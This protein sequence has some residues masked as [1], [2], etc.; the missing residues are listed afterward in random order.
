MKTVKARW[1]AAIWIMVG[2]SCGFILAQK[3]APAHPPADAPDANSFSD[4]E[5][6][7]RMKDL[8]PLAQSYLG[9]GRSSQKITGVRLTSA[10]FALSLAG[11][12][13]S[14]IRY[15]DVQGVGVKAGYVVHW[16]E[17][18]LWFPK[19][20]VEESGRFS[21][22]LSRL[23]DAAHGGRSCD[24]TRYLVDTKAELDAFTQKTAEWR[25]LTSKPT[26]SDEVIKKRLLA[27]DAIE[28]KNL[29]A[30][31]GYYEAGVALDPA[32]A[33]G[34]Y[35]AA[36]IYAEQQDY[37]DAAFYMKHYLI[38]LPDA[39]DATAAKEKLLLWEA[40]AEESG[41]K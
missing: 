6:C 18:I 37:F 5:A 21:A 29:Q 1:V 35:N 28:H 24:C 16:S 10:G 31:V 3:P 19:E 7:N 14:L 34:W 39:P 30:A 2:V 12:P 17:G 22:A 27:E 32:W 26:F 8:L 38:L 41:G 11:K 23:S 13:D 33:Q 25:A 15:S 20:R 4:Q 9:E 40:K 36:L